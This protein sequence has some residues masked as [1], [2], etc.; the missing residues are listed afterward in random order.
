MKQLIRLKFLIA[1]PIVAM[2]GLLCTKNS[3]AGACP[4]ISYASGCNDLITLGPGGSAS[5][6]FPVSTPYDDVEDQLV[7]VQNNTGSIVNSINLTG[8]DIFG[9]EPQPNSDGAGSTNP[10]GNGTIGPYGVVLGAGTF[11][12]TG[13]EGPNTSFTIFTSSTGT[14]NFTS[15][16]MANGGTAWFSLEEAPS[17]NGFSVTGIGI[18]ATPEPSTLALFGTGILLMGVMASRRKKIAA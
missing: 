7:G 14:V 1:L 5:I 2:L 13:Y 4:S 15:G 12:P 9:F 10:T 11:G 3:F 16:G 6:T 18:A 17:V 8:S